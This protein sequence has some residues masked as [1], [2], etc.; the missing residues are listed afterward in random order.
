MTASPVAGVRAEATSEADEADLLVKAAA[1]LAPALAARADKA[2]ALQRLPDETIDDLEAAELTKLAI[3]RKY[4]GSQASVTTCLRV[5]EELARG[6]ASTSFVN[7]AYFSSAWITALLSD[8]AQEEV[9]SS[10]NPRGIAVFNP[11]GGMATPKD[12]GFSL[13]GRWPFASGQ[14]HAGWGVVFGLVPTAEGGIDVGLFLLPR[15]EFTSA[16]DWNVVGMAATGSNT[17]SLEEA[18]VPSHRTLLL[19]DMMAGNFASSLVRDEP[20]YQ[21]P[22]LPFTS[23]AFAGTPLGMA[24]AALQ[25]FK[26]RV[27]NR[28]IT[29]TPYLRQADAA[30]THL[31]MAEAQMKVD[32]ARFHAT[33]L[34]AAAEG[35]AESLDLV[36]RARCR[37]DIAWDIKLCREAVDIVESASGGSAI[38]KKDPLQ[39]I[40]RDMR[41]MSVHSLFLATSNAELYGRV[42][43]GLEPGVPFV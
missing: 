40:I 11:M 8:E 29:Y 15:S 34:I 9:F 13:S 20:Y 18:F 19:Q 22:L 7:V 36:A 2:E 37:A 28:G 39:R 3:P 10:D 4:G 23:A 32:E 21:A 26:D 33:R 25:M 5:M 41:A 30:V 12:G 27:G 42:L 35:S 31:Q 43:C 16:D 14:H 1:E 38:H 17:L 24:E 6:C